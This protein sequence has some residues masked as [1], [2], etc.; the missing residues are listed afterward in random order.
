MIY[1]RTGQFIQSLFVIRYWS[2]TSIRVMLV[3]NIFVGLEKKILCSSWCNFLGFSF[4]PHTSLNF[5]LACFHGYCKTW[6]LRKHLWIGLLCFLLCICMQ[7]KEK[8]VFEDRQ[9]SLYE[10][11]LQW[12]S[13]LC[14]SV[15]IAD[16]NTAARAIPEVS[17]EVHKLRVWWHLSGEGMAIGGAPTGASYLRT[18][19][20][21]CKSQQS[22]DL[23]FF[24][25]HINPT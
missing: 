15:W 7:T 17:W 21:P 14:F 9:S 24:P 3:Q 22:S 12:T 2:I 18:C 25:P 23:I 13:S 4:Y 16:F 8:A 1:N 5:W 10:L 11:Q 6:N 20:F 19:P